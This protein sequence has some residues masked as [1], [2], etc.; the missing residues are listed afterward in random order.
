MIKIKIKNI[1]ERKREEERYISNII[2]HGRK[3]IVKKEGI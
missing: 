3:K 2:K 1:Y